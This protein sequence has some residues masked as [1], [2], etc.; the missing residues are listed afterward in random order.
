LTS[1]GV[2]AVLTVLRAVK[3]PAQIQHTT[4]CNR[5]GQ[6]FIRIIGPVVALGEGAEWVDLQGYRDERECGHFIMRQT[7]RAVK[8]A[9]EVGD[10]LGA[11]AHDTGKVALGDELGEAGPHHE[12]ERN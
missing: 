10:K 9:A 4:L 3:S 8:I 2:S 5:K 11:V 12:C 7:Y 1:F 6:T